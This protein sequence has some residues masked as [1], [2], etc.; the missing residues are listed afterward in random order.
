VGYGLDRLVARKESGSNA[1][2]EFTR[3]TLTSPLSRLS[4]TQLYTSNRE[5]SICH[6]DSGGPVF[7]G[8]NVVVALGNYV[9]NGRCQGTNSGPRLDLAPVQSFLDPYVD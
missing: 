7:K 1:G 3:R 8:D 4:K 6:G 5:G 9:A 2:T